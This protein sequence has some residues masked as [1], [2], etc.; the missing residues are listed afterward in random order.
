[1][2]ISVFE[3]QAIKEFADEYVKQFKKAIHKKKVAR[4]RTLLPTRFSRPVNTTGKLA[5]SIK[6]KI[7][8]SG[9]LFFTTEDYLY[10]LIYGRK[11]NSKMPPIAAISAWM[12]SK[13]IKS[14]KEDKYG[15]SPWAIA[16]SIAKNGSTIYRN[17]KGETSNLLNDIPVDEMLEKLYTKLGDGYLQSVN[18]SILKNLNEEDLN[19]EL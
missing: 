5:K 11:P 17:Y 14:D 16:K 12:K 2:A 4:R 6:Y 8:T 19:F 1:M 18:F 7:S 13:G 15:V 10:W 9:E 3:K